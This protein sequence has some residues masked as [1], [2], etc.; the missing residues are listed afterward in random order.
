MMFH[1]MITSLK[2]SQGSDETTISNIQKM[3]AAEYTKKTYAANDIV[4]HS[5]KLYY[6]KEEIDP[7]DNSWTASHWQETTLG[8][9]IMAL[10]PEE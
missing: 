3:I 8:A 7:A 1:S 10:Q 6:A 4:R 5:G 9:E 2:S